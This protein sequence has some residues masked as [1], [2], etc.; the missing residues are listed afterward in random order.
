MA[1]KASL[2]ISVYDNTTFLKAVLDSLARQTERNFEIVISEDAE[3]D[4]MRDFVASYGF[5]NDYRH[6][7]RPDTGWRKNAALNNAIRHAQSDWLIFIDGDCVLHP[8]FVEFHTALADERY[9]LAGKRVKLDDALSRRLLADPSEAGAG[10]QRRLLSRLI[11]P[12]GCEFVE[13]GLFFDPKGPLGFIP[14]IRKVRNLIGSN[15]SFSRRAI[16]AI[17]GFDEDYILPAFGE[18]RDLTWRFEALGYKHRSVRNLAVQYHL[19][20]RENWSQQEEN[21]AIW[22]EKSARGEYRCKN[23]LVK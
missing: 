7:T 23:G 17:N 6:I 19:K 21:F 20:H 13:D 14:A 4:S 22:R 2:I 15:M 12:R 16:E 10:M 3:H 18:D 11:A 5:V 9:I 1:Y 8:R